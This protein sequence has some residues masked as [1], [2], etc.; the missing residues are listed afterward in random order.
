M[1]STTSGDRIY[2]VS[3]LQSWTVPYSGNYDQRPTFRIDE[4]V[5][6]GGFRKGAPP[7]R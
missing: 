7:D 1:A 5:R 2:V 6:G 3:L 4:V